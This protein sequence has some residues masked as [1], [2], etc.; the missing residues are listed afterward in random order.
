MLE[1]LRFT[2][3]RK[4]FA[5]HVPEEPDDP[6]CLGAIAFNPPGQVLKRRGV[7]LDTTS[8]PKRLDNTIEG[9]AVLPLRGRDQAVSH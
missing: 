7:E 9:N 1:R 3:A 2:Y 8:Q 6:E 5:L 4:R